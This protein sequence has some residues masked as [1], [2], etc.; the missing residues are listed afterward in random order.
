M[1]LMFHFVC[2]K[3][4]IIIIIIIIIEFSAPAGVNIVSKEEEKRIKYQ[5]L[6]GQLPRLWP[7]YTVSLLVMVIG[8]VG[9]MRK[10][11]LFALR[12][13]PPLSHRRGV[14]DLSLFHRYSIGFCSSELTS[15][16]PLLSELARSHPKAVVLHTSRTEGY[17][18][19]FAPECLRAWNGLPED[20]LV[21]PADSRAALM[22]L[23]SN[24]YTSKLVWDCHNTL[25]TLAK[26]K[27][28]T[29]SW[30]PSHSGIIGNERADRCAKEGAG[31]PLTGPEPACGIAYGMARTA[32]SRWV[33]DEHQV[34]WDRVKLGIDVENPLS[35]KCGEAVETAKHVIFD[36]PALC[37]RRSSYLE[38]VQEEERQVSILQCITQFAKNLGWDSV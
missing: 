27:R 34:H 18:Y 7:N 31:L 23:A 8:S 38:V 30:V 10:T 4:E 11:L 25:K 2:G 5:E 37:R 29:L 17:D 13:M 28:V 15:I 14:G 24:H 22:A 16:I 12:A 36:C 20:V 33:S 32:V 1:S 3:T 26:T 21:G 35:R 19:T 9:K 6:L